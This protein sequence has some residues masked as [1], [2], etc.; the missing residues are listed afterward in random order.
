MMPV[1]SSYAIVC[2]ISQTELVCPSYA[3]HFYFFTGNLVGVCLGYFN[4]YYWTMH[5]KTNPT[6]MTGCLPPEGAP[7]HCFCL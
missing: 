4:S 6:T 2:T 1:D 5:T 3:L 7:L